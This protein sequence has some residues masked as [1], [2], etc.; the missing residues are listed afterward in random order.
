MKYNEQL[1]ERIAEVAEVAGYLWQKGWAERNGGNI[2]YNVTDVVDDA[3]RALTPLGESIALARPVENLRSHFFLVTGTN[4]RMRYISSS[5][6]DNMAIIRI[7]DDGRSYA[8]V[9]EK[10]IHPT[11][12]LPSHLSIH[13]YL[14]GKGRNQKAVIHTHPTELVA[15][16]H[17]EA[18]LGKDILSRLLWS[19]IPETRA[20]CPKGVGIVPY[21][22]PGSIG[23]ADAT[24]VQ[25]DEY[26]VVL[27]EKHGALGVGENVVEPFDMIDTL[28]KSAQIYMSGC[29]M[30][31]QPAGLSDTQMQELK[32]AFNL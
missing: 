1:A 14:L 31:F 5:P 2:S 17:N 28:S 11:S 20:F 26:D 25:L 12:E 9:A 16:T 10:Y 29:A 19:M 13:D 4:R 24:I 6:M 7:S 30:G 23:L 21:T 22:L 27:W 3:V 15:M 18:F 8:I 32:D